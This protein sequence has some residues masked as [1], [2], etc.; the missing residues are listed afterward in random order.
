MVTSSLGCSRLLPPRAVGF[1]EQVPTY[2]AWVSF[3]LIKPSVSLDLPALGF[4]GL[5]Q[6]GWLVVAGLAREGLQELMSL[7]EEDR[8]S[9]IN[10]FS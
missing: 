4:D 1:Q 8:L 2:L 3:L 7:S 9:G 6:G 5:N 10:A